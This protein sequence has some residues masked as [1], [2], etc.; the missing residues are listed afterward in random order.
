MNHGGKGASKRAMA[1]VAAV[2]LIAVWLAAGIRAL[3]PESEFGIL[4]GPSI[5]GYPR[6]A[7]GK[8]ALAPPGLV[9]LVTY[10]RDA[11][12]LPLPQAEDAM[13][14]GADGSRY[15]FRGWATLRLRPEAWA[16]I[17]AADRGAGVRDLLLEAIQAAGAGMD[18]GVH[19]NLGTRAFQDELRERLT[20]ELSGRGADLRELSLDSLDFLLALEGRSYPAT[21]TRMLVVGLDGADWVILDPLLA[22]GRLPNLQRLIE[23]GARTKLMTISPMLSPVIWTTIAT[24][25][26]PSRHGILDFLVQDPAGGNKQPVTSAQRKTATVWEM[27]GQAGIRTGVV[28]WWATWPA[29][30]VNGYLVSERIAYQLFDFKTDP[31]DAEGKTWPPEL[32]AEIRDEIVSPDAIPWERT[33]SYLLPEAS[34]AGEYRGD[35]KDLLDSF[36]TLLASGDSY[37]GIS[38]RLR[39]R[40]SPGFEAV[41]LEGTDTVGHLFMSF[42][43]PRLPGVDGQRQARFRAVVDRYYEQADRYLGELLADRGADWT[44]M[45]LS[46]HGFASDATRPRTADSR[47]GH[48]QAASWHRKFGMLVLSGRHIIPGAE[49]DQASVYDIAPTILALYGQP[50]PSSWPGKVLAGAIEP[51]FLRQHPVRFRTA[52]PERAD[53]VADGGGD[54]GDDDLLQK[55]KSLGYISSES[56]QSDS[57]T[58]RNNSGV[59]LMSEGNYS[60]AEAEFRAGLKENGEQPTL[61][62]NLGLTVLMQ[63]RRA[64]AAAIFER[65]LQYPHAY[66]VAAHHLARLAMDDNDN[67]RAGDLLQSILD[68]E[69]DAVE[70]ITTLGQVREK[71]GDVAGA[72]QA[73]KR[74]AALDPDMAQPRNHLGNLA[75]NRGDGVEAERWYLAAI[76]ADPYF[77]GAYNNLAL[78]YQDRG[79]IGKAIDLYGRALE[80]APTNAVVMNNLASLYFATGDLDEADRLWQRAVL[81]DPDYPSPYNN[82]A[83]IRI[84]R[85][86]YDSAE[87]LLKRALAL[88]P[89][90][91]DARVNLALVFRSRGLTEDARRELVAAAGDP[92]AR[93]QARL[94]QGY[95]ELGEGR[96]DEGLQLL[97]EARGQVGESP[98]LLNVRG[99]AALR[100]GRKEEALSY[101]KRSLD[102]DRSQPRLAERVGQLEQAP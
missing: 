34:S 79:E 14:P 17:A 37:I 29:E 87:E 46:D 10:P 82:L 43:D 52:D 77:M 95:L 6:L 31:E 58:A 55:L 92:R 89:G 73:W 36:R 28:G 69:P 32:Y 7:D 101:W 1:L 80:K 97:Q 19:R 20:A 88:E 54:K 12:V 25:V 56:N 4:H 21:D 41:Y 81:A 85:G 65:A 99:E 51:E 90:Y 5:L 62:V 67:A 48:G 26:E 86:E 71:L 100:L 8:L 64:E 72:E 30:P 83:G 15:G 50:V 9:G 78:V 98:A 94:Q 84:S 27:L 39:R 42:R 44:V 91:G 23:G 93:S 11:V 61:L 24:G 33:A 47:I 102:L 38:G 40:F 76:G 70:I 45:V 18:Q 74:A 57:I 16:D 66:R 22:A 49:L 13:I 60:Q 35:D 3:R 75:R 68:R 96:Y 2:V 59:A 53:T 63:E